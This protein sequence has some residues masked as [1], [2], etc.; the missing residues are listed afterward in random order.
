MLPIAYQWDYNSKHQVDVNNEASNAD[1]GFRIIVHH[2]RENSPAT[3][4]EYYSLFDRDTQ[5]NTASVKCTVS[6]M[7]HKR[8]DD[9]LSIHL[10]HVWTHCPY[11]CQMIFCKSNRNTVSNE[12]QLSVP[13][14]VLYFMARL[15]RC[16]AGITAKNVRETNNAT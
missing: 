9:T 15:T 3:S 13:L 6:A 1:H 4:R 12:Y 2:Q 8:N 11:M 14:S 7:L 16:C 5:R 10:A